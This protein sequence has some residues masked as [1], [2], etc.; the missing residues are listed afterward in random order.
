MIETMCNEILDNF[1][2]KEYQL[3]TASFATGE[4]LRLNQVMDALGFEYPVYERFEE[5][6]A[7]G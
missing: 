7:R 4:K 2:K 1:T 5:A 3:M 6:E